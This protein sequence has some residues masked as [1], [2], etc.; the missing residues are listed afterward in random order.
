MMKT[1]I[2]AS[3]VGKIYYKLNLEAWAEAKLEVARPDLYRLNKCVVFT[4]LLIKQTKT[5]R[6]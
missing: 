6:F 2:A 1:A 3:G 5:T 4:Q